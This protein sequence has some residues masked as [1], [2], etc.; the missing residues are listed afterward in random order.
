MAETVT[1]PKLGFDMAEGTLVR[2]VKAEGEAVSKG[3]VLAEIETDK[4]TVEVESPYSG[5]VHQQLVEQGA[6]V[7]VGS[8]IAVVT[9]PGETLA[10]S[11]G[12]KTEPMPTE[13]PKESSEPKIQPKPE[14]NGGAKQAEQA[15]PASQPAQTPEPPEEGEGLHAS[16][17]ARKMAREQGLDLSTVRGSGPGGRVVRK[18]IEAALAAPAASR[19]TPTPSPA[20][21][22]PAPSQAPQKTPVILPTPAWSTNVKIPADESVPLER[23]RT[24]I[25]RRM[26]ESETAG[27]SLLRNPRI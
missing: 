26:T 3:E 25:G 17:L 2:W 6:V 1:M 18:D 13:S 16:P 14:T 21:T 27:S 12:G 11:E 5:V 23:L 9:A 7:P 8:P 24:A 22:G 20:P 15:A 19:P 10:E 4:A